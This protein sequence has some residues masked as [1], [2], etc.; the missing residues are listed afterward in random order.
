MSKVVFKDDLDSKQGKKIDLSLDVSGKHTR[1]DVKTS[2][3]KSSRRG[4][5]KSRSA[6]DNDSS[7]R[8][9]S[10]KENGKKDSLPDVHDSRRAKKTELTE[11]S[12]NDN[13]TTETG[14]PPTATKPT[15]R[16]V[17]ETYRQSQKLSYD[18]V[19]YYEKMNKVLALEAEKAMD[20]NRDLNLRISELET[21]L[22]LVASMF[23]EKELQ[24]ER[25]MK[26]QGSNWEESRL[27]Q[28]EANRVRMEQEQKS[29]LNQFEKARDEMQGVLARNRELVDD[30]EDLRS[31]L[32]RLKEE[33][34]AKEETEKT[35]REED[36]RRKRDQEANKEDKSVMVEIE[37]Q[38]ANVGDPL[39]T[40]DREMKTDEL[41][42]V[43]VHVNTDTKQFQNSNTDTWDLIETDVKEAMTDPEKPPVNLQHAFVFPM[44]R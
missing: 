3:E 34:K 12:D 8:R 13:N 15:R 35:K 4:K 38:D 2:Q 33:Q 28:E 41:I 39:E 27:K 30:N 1:P 32:Y 11:L 42:L 6:E 25:E 23:K 29:L 44:F 31:Q 21:K 19:E 7:L 24:K 18:T 5:D 40:T 14:L 10:R 22:V 16:D 36:E 43:D 20:E 17:A 37:C 26:K 9:D